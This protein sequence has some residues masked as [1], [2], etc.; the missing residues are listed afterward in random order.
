MVQQKLSRVFTHSLL[1]DERFNMANSF[2]KPK[3][4]KPVASSASKKPAFPAAKP[5]KRVALSKGTKAPMAKS[6]AK[7]T[8][9]PKATV[10]P[11]AK[12]K[13]NGYNKYKDATDRPGFQYGK[14]TM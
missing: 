13:P 9:K 3:A 6:T 8:A 2:N 4:P 1:A 12:P 14:G 11:T 5:V 10:K 7:P